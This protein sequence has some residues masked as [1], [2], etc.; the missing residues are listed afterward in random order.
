MIVA[1]MAVLLLSPDVGVVVAG[2]SSNKDDVSRQ[3]VTGGGVSKKS[4]GMPEIHKAIKEGKAALVKDILAKGTDINT[5]D[6]WDR[7]TPLMAAIRDNQLAIAALLIDGGADV[8]AKSR[9]MT[10]PLFLAIDKDDPTLVGSLLKKGADVNATT[11]DDRDTPL[12]KA[13]HRGNMEIIKMLLDKGASVNAVTMIGRN[14][15]F[16]AVEESNMVLLEELIKKG[17]D[18]QTR[19]Q[20]G[21]TT[22]MVASEKGDKAIAALLLK[23]KVSLDARVIASGDE[24]I[25]TDGFTALMLA[26]G[27]GQKEVVKLL[28]QAGGRIT[29]AE[30][31]QA[32]EWSIRYNVRSL[33]VF[34]DIV[35]QE[36]K[37]HIE[38]DP[39]YVVD[40]MAKLPG[41]SYGVK[42]YYGKRLK[43]VKGNLTAKGG[44]IV[45][46]IDMLKGVSPR[47]VTS[48]LGRPDQ[49]K[50]DFQGKVTAPQLT[51]DVLNEAIESNEIAKVKK[52][53]AKGLDV[54][55]VGSR[56]RPLFFSVKED[57]DPQI[58]RLL[59]EKGADVNAP[60]EKERI[61]PLMAA[62]Y[63][64]KQEVVS[65][66]IEKGANVNARGEN[67]IT[68]LYVAVAEG[69]ADMV[70]LL[71]QK[72][73]DPHARVDWDGD[74]DK[75]RTTE[76]GLEFGDNLLFMALM[77]GNKEIIDLLRQAGAKVS[78]LDEK[79]AD[80]ARTQE[81]IGELKSNLRQADYAALTYISK[82]PGKTITDIQQLA[83]AGYSPSPEITL[84]KCSL[85]R[86]DKPSGGKNGKGEIKGSDS[87]PK[88]KTSDWRRYENVEGELI[89]RHAKLNKENSAAV[90]G[91][92]GEGRVDAKGGI[93]VPKLKIAPSDAAILG[94]K[95]LEDARGL[96]K[97]E[98]MIVSVAGDHC[99]I[100]EAK[101]KKWEGRD[102]TVGEV[103][104]NGD[105][106]VADLLVA[107]K[108]VGSLT[109]A[110]GLSMDL[111]DDMI[112]VYERLEGGK[113]KAAPVERKGQNSDFAGDWKSQIGTILT[114]DGSSFVVKSV[115]GADKQWDGKTAMEK[116][117]KEG[118]KW[119]ADVA[120]R[121]P[122]RDGVLQLRKWMYAELTWDGEKLV[123]KARSS[124]NISLDKVVLEAGYVG[125]LIIDAR[126]MGTRP[127]MSPTIYDEK[128]E[129]LYGSKV[130]S[131]DIGVE[132][133]VT[134]Y[135]RYLEQAW[136]NP[137]FAV[138]PINVL[139]IRKTGKS[140]GDL[141]VSNGDAERIRKLDGKSGFLKNC[142]VLIVIRGGEGS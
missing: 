54:N 40:S 67:G 17:G 31:K 69:K 83:D 135:G 130:C 12:I 24:K 75:P 46:R 110:E 99:V 10:T 55:F 123:R 97:N 78:P 37:L 56:Y 18:V 33:R 51:V 71:L 128:G 116:I 60:A 14:A 47:L 138:N 86:L 53:L 117:R 131:K 94:R 39:A 85:K 73:A 21:V 58:I 103:A 28:Q 107:G 20:T 8:N 80:Y 27:Q 87:K 7:Y 52:L 114:S 98:N 76:M 105:N 59:I 68:P 26:Y 88:P 13:A 111:D 48:P 1:L 81:L 139:A 9:N 134:S 126:F 101:G 100:R 109:I 124:V 43:F 49:G 93:T 120:F 34:L 61:T 119:V 122:D 6:G 140:D 136:A 121:L 77:K 137:R 50:V 82:N 63:I 74:A 29:A 125:G 95:R 45:L 72:G 104:W 16:V 11:S 89:L 91:T 32:K 127:D 102:M 5:L 133:G 90:T 2:S 65:L 3:A 19:L 113:D 22:L 30:K 112:T 118:D 70:R 106:W 38:K 41:V 92:D 84:V 141:V 44:E 79:R 4:D 42:L 129:I 62:V 25:N 23:N 57:K 132:R 96:W 15:A 142:R 115:N 66:L 64:G 35:H 108:K 36:A